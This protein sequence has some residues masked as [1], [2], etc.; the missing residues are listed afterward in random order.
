MKLKSTVWFI[1]ISACLFITGC[2][3]AVFLDNWYTNTYTPSLMPYQEAIPDTSVPCTIGEYGSY[4][5]SIT[6]RPADGSQPDSVLYIYYETVAVCTKTYG[7]RPDRKQY[8]YN[9][10]AQ[11]QR[12]NPSKVVEYSGVYSYPVD[13]PQNGTY[14]G[15]YPQFI[16]EKDADIAASLYK[17]LYQGEAEVVSWDNAYTES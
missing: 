9:L 10:R 15:Y 3:I 1:V 17:K 11:D 6:C 2:G 5:G 12:E 14:E 13:N 7:N 16:Q 8:D 4:A